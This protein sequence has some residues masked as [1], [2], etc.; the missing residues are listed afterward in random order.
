SACTASLSSS[1]LS[2]S[3]RN[4]IFAARSAMPC[5]VPLPRAPV[6]AVALERRRRLCQRGRAKRVAAHRGSAHGGYSSEHPVSSTPA[7]RGHGHGPAARRPRQRSEE[8]TSELQSR[9]N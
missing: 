8:H 4:T 9:E 2:T 1:V 5:P 7:A 6:Y 3:N